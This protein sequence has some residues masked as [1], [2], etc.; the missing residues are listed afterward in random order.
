MKQQNTL[1]K[2]VRC[3]INERGD[4]MR[5]LMLLAIVAVLLIPGLVF[6]EEHQKGED[7]WGE[8]E[9]RERELELEE[10][11][12][13]MDF[14]RQHKELELERMRSQMKTGDSSRQ[15]PRPSRATIKGKP[16]M[17]DKPAQAKF[18]R[19]MHGRAAHGGACGMFMLVCIIVHILLAVWTYKDIRE[20]TNSSGIWIV[21][22]LL[23]G[24][25]GAIVYA[26]V[27]LGDIKR[28]QNT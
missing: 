25:L 13:E 4:K 3:N 26:I 22:V 9:V 11:R 28:Q 15:M 5:K 8:F 24:L 12:M 23:T 16:M 27:R 19:G 17:K 21:I 2:Y 10:R 6:A 7:I 1:T 20:K 18:K 14:E